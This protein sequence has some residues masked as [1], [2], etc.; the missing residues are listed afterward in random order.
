MGGVA[1]CAGTTNATLRRRAASALA[2]WITSLTSPDALSPDMGITRSNGTLVLCIDTRI[3]FVPGRFQGEHVPQPVSVGFHR[4]QRTISRQDG[5]GRVRGSVERA[6]RNQ[7]R[8]DPRTAVFSEVVVHRPH[9]A[10]YRQHADALRRS[11]ALVPDT[12]ARLEEDLVSGPRCSKAV[13][14]LFVVHEKTRIEIANFRQHRGADQ[15]ERSHHLIDRAR[16]AVIELGHPIC[17]QPSTA[18]KLSLIHI[19]EPTRL[20]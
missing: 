12:R 11:A 1:A 8:I 15:K 4:F 20:L 7:R 10:S 13:I 6:Y 17:V 19:S 5:T 9:L 16:R 2:T 3:R 18:R 14:H